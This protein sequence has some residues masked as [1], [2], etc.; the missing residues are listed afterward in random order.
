[1]AWEKMLERCSMRTTVWRM[2]DGWRSA[3]PSPMMTIVSACFKS[4][5]SI[6]SG[7]GG[8]K[9]GARICNMTMAFQALEKYAPWAATGGRSPD[10]IGE[11]SSEFVPS[12]YSSF[13]N[14]LNLG[15]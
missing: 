7:K 12:Y 2:K 4:V 3:N 6:R 10:E 1:M 15:T 9:G 8:V 14:S 5:V 11:A 13:L